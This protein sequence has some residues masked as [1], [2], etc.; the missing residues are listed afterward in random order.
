MHSALVK[1][2]GPDFLSWRTLCTGLWLG[3]LQTKRSQ[4]TVD[5]YVQANLTAVLAKLDYP[6][7]LVIKGLCR[8]GGPLVAF[9]VKYWRGTLSLPHSSHSTRTVKFR[10]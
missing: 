6:Q 5:R 2:S 4:P 7:N 8:H 10:W 1:L 9:W 3:Q